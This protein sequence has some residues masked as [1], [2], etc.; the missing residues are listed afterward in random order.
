MGGSLTKRGRNQ[1]KILPNFPN[2]ELHDVAIERIWTPGSVPAQR[3]D[4]FPYLDPPL[5]IACSKQVQCSFLSRFSHLTHPN[6]R[7]KTNIQLLETP[8]HVSCCSL[9]HSYPEFGQICALREKVSLISISL[10]SIP[11]LSYR[12]SFFT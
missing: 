11:A 5:K 3:V 8:K 7:Q 6:V 12:P 10:L 4:F 9:L 1:H 2:F